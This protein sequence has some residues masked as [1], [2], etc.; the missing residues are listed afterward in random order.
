[1]KNIKNK[2]KVLSILA[3]LFLVKTTPLLA[4]EGY[5][6]KDKLKE[7]SSPFINTLYVIA[8][9]VGG[10]GIVFGLAAQAI[11]YVGSSDKEQVK[12]KLLTESVIIIIVC[13]ILI[14]FK[15]FLE[16]FSFLNV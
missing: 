11:R 6:N 7:V 14:N 8:G 9:W 4:E 3:V 5:I 12:K 1:M 16:I 2:I 13:V 15:K 10:I